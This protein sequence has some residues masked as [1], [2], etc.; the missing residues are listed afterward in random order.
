MQVWRV[1]GE[2]NCAFLL[3]ICE[4]AGIRNNVA[5][6]GSNGPLGLYGRWQGVRREPRDYAL[7]L[8]GDSR[9]E[10]RVHGSRRRTSHDVVPVRLP[11]GSVL[12]GIA[13]GVASQPIIAGPA[14]TT[15]Q[16][17]A[18]V[19]IPFREVCLTAVRATCPRSSRAGLRTSGSSAEWLCARE[20]V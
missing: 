8:A 18:T 20:S 5:G 15:C 9:T 12:R 6:A 11:V 13:E 10:T 1:P 19:P 17:M 4:C 16:I 7:P 3:M 2:I 14:K